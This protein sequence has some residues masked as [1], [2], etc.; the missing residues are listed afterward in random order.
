MKNYIGRLHES[1]LTDEQV[2]E[3][4]DKFMG[5]LVKIKGAVKNHPAR[6]EKG[7]ENDLDVVGVVNYIGRNDKLGW[8]LQ[9]TLNRTPYTD[10]SPEDIEILP[11]DYN[12]TH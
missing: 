6:G 2:R 1:I 9:V 3:L 4:Q 5:K 12:Y 7:Y 10:I 11:D 8:P